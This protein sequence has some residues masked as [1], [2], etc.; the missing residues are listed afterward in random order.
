MGIFKVKPQ[1]PTSR[2]C[3][4]T[5][6]TLIPTTD[7]LEMYLKFLNEVT[8]IRG[9]NRPLKFVSST[10]QKSRLAKVGFFVSEENLTSKSPQDQIHFYLKFA[11]TCKIKLSFEERLTFTNNKIIKE[12]FICQTDQH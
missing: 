1:V 12:G 10:F 5:L 7:Y 11:P 3:P 8:I 2:Y 6:V 9:T 4:A